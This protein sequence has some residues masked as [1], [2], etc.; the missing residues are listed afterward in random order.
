LGQEVVRASLLVLE[1]TKGKMFEVTK[2]KKRKG[3]RRLLRSKLEFTRL[4][5]GEIVI[6]E[7]N[8]EE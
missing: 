5:V 7:G 1:H 3:Y 8:R 4:R 6:G 2:F